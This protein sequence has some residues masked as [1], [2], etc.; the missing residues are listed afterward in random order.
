M[1]DLHNSLRKFVTGKAI[2]DISIDLIMLL[3]GLIIGA[4]V[5]ILFF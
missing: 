4:Y 2:R 1:S 3:S 5:K